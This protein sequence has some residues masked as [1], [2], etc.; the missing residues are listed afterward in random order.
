MLRNPPAQRP[1]RLHAIFAGGASSQEA[2][3]NDLDI[4][5]ACV[6]AAVA[7]LH[8][9]PLALAAWAR[10][11]RFRDA[12]A[13]LSDLDFLTDIVPTIDGYH[14][15]LEALKAVACINL[16]PARYSAA[17]TH[18]RA[19]SAAAD[20]ACHS[21]QGWVALRGG[22]SKVLALLA[23]AAALRASGD[24][25][26]ALAKTKQAVDVS[27][28]ARAYAGESLAGESQLYRAH[29]L[30]TEFGGATFTAPRAQLEHADDTLVA[31]SRA[32][33]GATAPRQGGCACVPGRELMAAAIGLLLGKPAANNS[34]DLC[35][36][37]PAVALAF[38]RRHASDSA[39][40]PSRDDEI[41][42][43][44]AADSCSF[45][46]VARFIAL[47]RI[48]DLAR[49]AVSQKAVS[50]SVKAPQKV[51]TATPSTRSTTRPSS[52]P[53]VRLSRPSSA[54]A[55]SRRY[56]G[57]RAVQ[58]DQS[59]S[60]PAG[61]SSIPLRTAPAAR[62]A[63]AVSRNRAG[64]NS[65]PTK[66]SAACNAPAAD[67]DPTSILSPSAAS[68]QAKH[69]DPADQSP[70]T[71]SLAKV[72]LAIR[73]LIGPAQLAAAAL[74]LLAARESADARELDRRRRRRSEQKEREESVVRWEKLHA[75]RLSRGRSASTT[76]RQPR[77][78]EPESSGPMSKSAAQFGT[79]QLPQRQP[80]SRPQ[81]AA[82]LRRVSTFAPGRL[83]L[84]SSLPA[85]G[86]A[87]VNSPATAQGAGSPRRPTSAAV[88]PSTTAS[89]RV[90]HSVPPPPAPPTASSL[91][92]SGKV[93]PFV[94]EDND[95]DSGSDSDLFVSGAYRKK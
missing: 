9:W 48:I 14:A 88:P 11:L 77:G 8:P 10:Y 80:C 41:D 28:A 78:D 84:T 82:T 46:Q 31:F 19:A 61:A 21:A 92:V 32:G 59:A 38:A 62:P 2:L 45:E 25:D 34:R 64:R 65:E 93:D 3:S 42:W 33:H 40:E 13:L 73:T 94:Y 36:R 74:V 15:D 1:A 91:N 29:Q 44:R 22:R 89:P 63:S 81:S 37:M 68:S 43:T 26:T 56:G 79:S 30:L 6:C 54:Q 58:G 83:R 70:V 20:A 27:S 53:A 76:S 86:R 51:A 12:D 4:A 55:T 5:A 66:P 95:D 72:P 67:S 90:S 23:E 47:D 60:G 17:L 50:A 75:A 57:R 85:E 69:R 24:G 39:T 52:A 35:F 87:G 7:P 49:V 18:A 71:S 16:S